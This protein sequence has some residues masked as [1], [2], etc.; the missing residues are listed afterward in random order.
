ML[1]GLKRMFSRAPKLSGNLAAVAAWAETNRYDFRPMNDDDDSFLIEGQTGAMP[2]RLEWGPSQRSYVKGPELRLRAELE[3]AGGMQALVL[4]RALQSEM[5]RSVFEQYVEGVQ[6]RID[7]QTPPEMRWLVLYSK[8][9]PSEMGALR[10]RFSAVGA[11]KTWLMSWLEGP[12]T[13]ALLET[14]LVEGEPL[15]LMVGRGR[16]TLRASLPSP[17][18]RVLEERLR[19]FQVSLREARRA[20]EEMA[21][22]DISSSPGSQWPS[23]RSSEDPSAGD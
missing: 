4:D 20:A 14:P 10:E 15:A 19:L 23:G 3:A 1:N 18:P 8:L 9:E 7:N 12:L 17:T 16:L 22:A 21:G 2:W 13:T 6:T 11:S 5:E